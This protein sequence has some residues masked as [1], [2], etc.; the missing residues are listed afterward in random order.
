MNM[1]KIL[2]LQN[3]KKSELLLVNNKEHAS[4]NCHRFLFQLVSVLREVKYLDDAD[5]EDIP[6]EAA[7]IFA[8]KESYR[9]YVANVDLT[10]QWYNKV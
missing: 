10:Q 5:I 9:Q 1:L 3:V 4:V 8:A 6:E 2:F 7:K